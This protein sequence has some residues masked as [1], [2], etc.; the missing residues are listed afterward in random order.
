VL[1]MFTGEVTWFSGR[2]AREALGQVLADE[3]QSFRLAN[4][5]DTSPVP[6]TDWKVENGK[7]V[8]QSTNGMSMCRTKQEFPGDVRVEFEV[9]GLSGNNHDFNVFLCGEAPQEGA[10]FFLG[11]SGTSQAGIE[12][13]SETRW[14]PRLLALSPQKTYHVAVERSRDMLRLEVE[15]QL[16]EERS[17]VQPLLPRGGCHIGFFTWNGQLAVDNIKVRRRAVPLRPEPPVVA[18]AMLDIGELDRAMDAYRL[19]AQAYPSHPSAQEARLRLGTVLMSRRQYAQARDLFEEV[20]RQPA[21][22]DLNAHSLVLLSMVDQTVGDGVQSLKALQDLAD[23]EPDHPA[24]LSGIQLQ[25]DRM[26]PCL[27]LA[28]PMFYGCASDGE[29]VLRSLARA[30]PSHQTLFGPQHLRFAE[31][32]RLW[33]GIAADSGF[34]HTALQ[35]S[36]YYAREAPEVAAGLSIIQARHLRDLGRVNDAI[37]TLEKIASGEAFPDATRARQEAAIELGRT[38]AWEGRPAEAER[39][40]KTVA[41][42][43]KSAPDLAAQAEY[44]WGVATILSHRDPKSRW[45]AVLGK[46]GASWILR[47]SVLFL[48]GKLDSTALKSSFRGHAVAAAEIPLQQALFAL[49]HNNLVAWHSMVDEYVRRQPSTR[50]NPTFERSSKPRER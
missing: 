12:A 14:L 48:S 34:L 42:D 19:V 22:A 37:S 31:A 16:V 10:R 29:T 21:N 47:Q 2:T 5:S 1:E 45:D 35:F 4:A 27:D 39:W 44:E 46:D 30:V 23:D 20:S 8:G 28:Q 13:A 33:A 40:F 6:S 24:L 3:F 9:T 25:L 50:W 41:E 43:E 32:L 36:R 26:E 7:L 18:D 11:R 15:G 17:L 38:Q 49:E